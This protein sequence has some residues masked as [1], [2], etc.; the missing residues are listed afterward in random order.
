MTILRES[1][2]PRRADEQ[3]YL[4][5]ETAW[6]PKTG[7]K[8]VGTQEL[9]WNTRYLRA[10]AAVAGLFRA[11]PAWPRPRDRKKLSL[12]QSHLELHEIR[13]GEFLQRM[14]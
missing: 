1:T 10:D 12:R 6:N 8:H 11:G 2:A 13:V 3:M 7:P 4:E 9:C 5:M 14:S